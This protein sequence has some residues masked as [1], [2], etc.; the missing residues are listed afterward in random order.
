[1][2]AKT[3]SVNLSSKDVGR[4][5]V[6]DDGINDEA[7]PCCKAI[8]SSRFFQDSCSCEW[9]DPIESIE[10]AIPLPMV[11]FESVLLDAG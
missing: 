8:Q 10:K 9:S 3:R 5:G 1:M 6:S 7:F 4:L 2:Y 11:G